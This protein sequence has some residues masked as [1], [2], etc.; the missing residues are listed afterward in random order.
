M[1]QGRHS[2]AWASISDI[3]M[4]LSGSN[5]LS[6]KLLKA[7]DFLFQWREKN[8]RAELIGKGYGMIDGKVADPE[9]QFHQFMLNGYAYLGISRVAGDAGQY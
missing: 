2:G 6:P 5:K 9:D 3:H 4:I 7:C 8:K 1:K